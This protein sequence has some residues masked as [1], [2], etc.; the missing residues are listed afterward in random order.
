MLK[1]IL[2]IRYML[3]L[4]VILKNERQNKYLKKWNHKT[5][6][7]RIQCHEDWLPNK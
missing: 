2:Y 5:L 6:N 1:K 3:H 4:F 7:K